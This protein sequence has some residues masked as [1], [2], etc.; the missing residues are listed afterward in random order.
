MSVELSTARLA[1]RLPEERDADAMAGQANDLEVVRYTARIRFSYGRSDAV[2]FIRAARAGASNR[3]SAPFFIQLKNGG[4]LI[5]GVG[6]GLGAG[7]DAAELGYWIGCTHWDQGYASEA[8]AEILRFDFETLNLSVVHGNVVPENGAASRI[9]AKLRM[10][11]V[12]HETSPAPARDAD[13][14]V[15]IYEMTRDDWLNR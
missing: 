7:R 2:D 9:M 13:Q 10:T 6:L 15:D 3:R 14:D 1:L 8:V 11:V 12:G 5:G 4:A